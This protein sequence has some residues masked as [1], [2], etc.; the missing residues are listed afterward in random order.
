MDHPT[1]TRRGPQRPGRAT[2]QYR[3]IESVARSWGFTSAAYFSRRFRETYGTTPG[4]WRRLSNTA[5]TPSAATGRSR[6]TP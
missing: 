6:P 4:E 2:L 3:T 5:T 1:P